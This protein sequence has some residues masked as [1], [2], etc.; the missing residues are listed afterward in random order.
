MKLIDV[1]IFSKKDHITR[2]HP[3]KRC[4]HLCPLVDCGEDWWHYYN[5]T[6]GCPVPDGKIMD[7]EN[8]F[9]LL[10]KDLARL[11]EFHKNMN[12]RCDR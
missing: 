7:K 10:K 1:S 2:C 5:V 12:E 6:K 11:A 9:M 4:F 8:Y 3:T